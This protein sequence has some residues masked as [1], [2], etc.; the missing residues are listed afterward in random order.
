[1]R[2]RKE[3]LARGVLL[4]RAQAC[5]ERLGL[6][7]QSGCP[8][9]PAPCRTRA[10]ML[11]TEE[12][13]ISVASPRS[14]AAAPARVTSGRASAG[15]P[16]PDQRQPGFV[17]E[18]RER[19]RRAAARRVRRQL[20]PTGCGSARSGWPPSRNTDCLDRLHVHHAR[21][22]LA[23]EL[24]PQLG[25]ARGGRGRLAGPVRPGWTR[26]P[27]AGACRCGCR[28]GPGLPASSSRRTSSTAAIARVESPASR[29]ISD[30]RFVGQA[31][32]QDFRRLRSAAPQAGDHRIR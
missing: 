26:A 29:A 21:R 12:A 6:A 3:Q 25:A 24:D 20:P 5:V 4:L 13:R 2:A 10:R 7:E 15:S 32:D 18:R 19:C 9:P 30:R 27:A 28:C 23:P 8:A 22:V 11:T 17:L 14:R 31:A 1:M 16:Q